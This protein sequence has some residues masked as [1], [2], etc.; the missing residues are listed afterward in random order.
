MEPP[1][2]VYIV[3]GNEGKFREASRI[4]GEYG[5]EARQARLV[6]VEIQSDRLEDIALKAARIAYVQLRRPLIVEDA[7]LFIDS[8]RG[9]PGP[10]SDYVYRTIGIEGILN[11]LQGRGRSACFR[12]AVAYVAPMA[13]KVFSGEVCGRIAEEPRG[14][15]G[16]GFDPI[17]IPE[18]YSQTFAELGIGVKNRV[19]HR[20]QALRKLASW[21]VGAAHTGGW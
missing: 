4:L 20:A 7:G 9:F 15:E 2:L 17:F 8:L 21:L 3:T 11:L 10:Y 16:F 19:S 18:G 5:I 6:K 12:S 13:E 14:S 1:R